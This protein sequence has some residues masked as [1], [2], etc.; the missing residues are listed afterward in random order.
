[1]SAEMWTGRDL[2][3]SERDVMEHAIGAAI[4]DVRDLGTRR[5]FYSAD[6]GSADDLIWQVLARDGLASLIRRPSPGFP[7][8]L[9]RVTDLG[10][11]AIAACR[12]KAAQ[13][14]AGGSHGR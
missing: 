2:T 1:M 4:N 6:P 8:N 14:E 5:N 7:G 12:A 13:A 10:R 3:A 9:W 11:S